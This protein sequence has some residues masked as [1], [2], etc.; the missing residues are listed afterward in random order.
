MSVLLRLTSVGWAVSTGLT[1][2]PSKNA[3]TASGAM[4][5][6]LI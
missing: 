2:A 5:D 3:L 4:F 6:W 1:S